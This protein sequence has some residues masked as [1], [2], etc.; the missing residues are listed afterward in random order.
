MIRIHELSKCFHSSGQAVQAVDGLSLHVEPGEVYGL[1]GPNGAG[2]T[3]TLRM[4]LGL[5]LPDQ[6]FAEVAGYRCGDEPMKVRAHTGMVSASDG[7]YSWLTA[8]EMLQFFCRS[9][10]TFSADCRWQH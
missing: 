4:M 5:L 7:V 3:T 1:L 2:K 9:L 6:G 8:R 10:W